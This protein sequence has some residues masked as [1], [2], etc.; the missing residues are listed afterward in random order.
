VLPP[1][2]SP[3]LED[4]V[5]NGI[6]ESAQPATLPHPGTIMIEG[7]INGR[8]DIDIYALGP[9]IRGDR[10]TV[11]ITGHDGLNTV[12]A[13]FDGF[14][15]L[16]DANDDRS[17]YGGLV[18]PYISRVIRADTANLFVGVAVSSAANFASSA[19]RFDS[20]TYTIK[21]TCQPAESVPEIHPQLVYMDFEGG[22]NVQIGLEPIAS[23]R[24][25]SAESISDRLAGRTEDIINMIIPL[26]KQDLAPYNVTLLD[27][28]H[29]PRPSE[30]HSTLYF[31]NFNS[32]YLGL[33]DN[34]DTGNASIQQEAII[35]SEDIAMFESLRPSA[36]EVAQAL[37]N[38]GSHEL[39]HLLGLEHTADPNDLMA[40]AATARQIL[41]NDASFIWA[42]LQPDVFPV[43]SQNN[44]TLLLRNVGANPFAASSRLILGG[45]TS[46][47]HA[48]WRDAAGL[49]DIPIVPCG[50]CAGVE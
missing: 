40:T 1:V 9:A 33:A 48:S 15:D 26:M 2:K 19:G 42:R 20:G 7:V 32:R 6:F 21:L 30:P 14:T 36:E 39:G 44:P 22:D 8:N 45:I 23:M 35:Y 10:I 31:G 29:D 24:P 25:F 47:K 38:V 28:R 46:P 34:V 17:F 3:V 16:I 4:N 27:S 18:D 12:A 41:E 43:G 50:R 5:D 13:L 11:E 49:A 37:A